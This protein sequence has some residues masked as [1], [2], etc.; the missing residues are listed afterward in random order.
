MFGKPP[1]PSNVLY[2]DKAPFTPESIIN[3]QNIYIWAEE[4]LQA[5]VEQDRRQKFCVNI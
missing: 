5:I 1:F 3:S 4:N 2:T